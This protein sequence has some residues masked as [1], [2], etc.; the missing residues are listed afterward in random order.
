MLFKPTSTPYPGAAHEA[1]NTPDFLPTLAF[2]RQAAEM[3]N[4]EKLAGYLECFSA[5]SQKKLRKEAA[6]LLAKPKE[7]TRPVV[8]V[9]STRSAVPIWAQD[10][11]VGCFHYDSHPITRG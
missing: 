2:H 10:D 11:E 1:A 5:G 9:T 7:L 3:A 8:S 6:L 4:A